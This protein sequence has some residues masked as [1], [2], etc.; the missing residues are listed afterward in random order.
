MGKRGKEGREGKEGKGRKF[1]CRMKGKS[2]RSKSQHGPQAGE[3]RMDI[4][5]IFHLLLWNAIEE[6]GKKLEMAISHE[7]GE[8]RHS[9]FVL[10]G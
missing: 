3:D 7:N 2:S 10:R 5:N 9:A 8:G 1:D 6:R 4:S